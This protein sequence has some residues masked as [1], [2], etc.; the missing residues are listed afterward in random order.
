MIA[1]FDIDGV[2]ADASHRQHHVAARPKDWDA[3]FAAVGADPVIHA[4]RDRLLA[5]AQRHEVVLL[6][7][8]PERTR[9]DTEAWLLAA[10]MGRPRVLLRD[11]Q[12]RRPAAVV[13]SELIS[14]L[15][16]PDQVAVVIDDDDS[17]VAALAA[18]GYSAELF[19]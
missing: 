19:R 4:G 6:S 10:G 17:V 18:M 12:D 1:I 14:T 13:K 2:L 7:G 3:F 8:R 9:T 16:P 15:A 11:D 5:E